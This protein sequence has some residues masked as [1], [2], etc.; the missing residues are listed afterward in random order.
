[1]DWLM[2]IIM[3]ING[4]ESSRSFKF[5]SS[6]RHVP[7]PAKPLSAARQAQKILDRTLFGPNES[8]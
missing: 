3:K 8:M 6:V 5:L 4:R 7:G 2:V 1:M